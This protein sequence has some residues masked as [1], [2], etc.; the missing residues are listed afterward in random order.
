MFTRILSFAIGFT[1]FLVVGYNI[2]QFDPFVGILVSHEQARRVTGG[3]SGGH[4]ID[5][6]QFIGPQ[7][8][9]GSSYPSTT[10]G[11]DDK[12]LA[13]TTSASQM[14]VGTGTREENDKGVCS[15]KICNGVS[16]KCGQ[17]KS[18]DCL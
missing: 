3:Q 16:I 6:W 4:G 2:G 9:T 17:K 18:N 1:A 12:V 8:C 11:C 10:L 7:V 15:S 13:C 5:R 14:L